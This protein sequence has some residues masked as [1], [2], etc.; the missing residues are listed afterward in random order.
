M[1]SVSLDRG[2]SDPAPDQHTKIMYTAIPV[3]RAVKT[4][5]SKEMAKFSPTLFYAL[6]WKVTASIR[7]QYSEF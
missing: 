2:L 7:N 1:T 6:T 5:E 4:E 3:L